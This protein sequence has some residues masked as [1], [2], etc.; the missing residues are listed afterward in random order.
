MQTGM[1]KLALALIPSSKLSTTSK[2]VALPMQAATKKAPSVDV[3][4]ATTI[5]ATGGD[6]NIIDGRIT[7]RDDIAATLGQRVFIDIILGLPAFDNDHNLRQPNNEH[8]GGIPVKANM[9]SEVTQAEAK[10]LI[11]SSKQV[12]ELMEPI[13]LEMDLSPA[14]AKLYLARINPLLGEIVGPAVQD[15]DMPDVVLCI[16]PENMTIPAESYGI[17]LEPMRA[18]LARGPL[19][20]GI[21]RLLSSGMQDVA[22]GRKEVRFQ[23]SFVQSRIR[24][25]GCIECS[26]IDFLIAGKNSTYCTAKFCMFSLHNDNQILWRIT[27]ST[28]LKEI[29]FVVHVYLKT[30]H[31]RNNSSS[32]CMQLQPPLAPSLCI[33]LPVLTL[34]LL[35][36]MHQTRK[37]TEPTPQRDSCEAP[38]PDSTPSPIR[39][40]LTD[41]G[42]GSL[43][44]EVERLQASLVICKI[45]GLYPGCGE[46]R[47]PAP[48][49]KLLLGGAWVPGCSHPDDCPIAYCGSGWPCVCLPL[50]T[51]L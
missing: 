49:S 34:S 33:H 4:L 18:V 10:G 36:C 1:P 37:D 22:N 3:A 9:W 13:K 29:R 35:P 38:S 51:W 39:L 16:T 14:V 7:M 32:L 43:A 26:R 17:T 2:K 23:T 48:G 45:I 19:A 21:L 31:V 41:E 25:D 28:L 6:L 50:D 15:E 27:V 8:L 40:S 47:Y 20:G 46:L 5:K 24:M 12:V 42:R 44:F 30:S 11:Y